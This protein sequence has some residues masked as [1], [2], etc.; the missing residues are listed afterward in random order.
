MTGHTPTRWQERLS[1]AGRGEEYPL[2]P[3]GVFTNKGLLRRCLEMSQLQTLRGLGLELKQPTPNFAG[4]DK[5]LRRFRYW[6]ID[7]PH[8]DPFEPTQR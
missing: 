4:V 3:S 2:T 6:D 1:R 7:I 5:L 8:E